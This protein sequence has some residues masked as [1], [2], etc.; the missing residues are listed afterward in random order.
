M[1]NN[2]PNKTSV[3][4]NAVYEEQNLF[5]PP[6]RVRDSSFVKDHA[7]YME[8]YN[9]SINFPTV[10]WAMQSRLLNWKKPFNRVFEGGLL[11]G[12]HNWYIGGKI[13]ASENC[14]DRHVETSRSSKAAIIW[15]GEKANETRT[16][17]YYDLY[18]EVCRFANVLKK[19]GVKKGDM[20]TLYMPQIPETAIAMLACTRIGAVHNVVF[21]GFSAE[22]LRERIIDSGSKVLVTADA[23]NRRGALLP[24]K[25][26]ADEALNGCPAV[27]SCIVVRHTGAAVNFEAPRDKWWHEEMSAQD[28]YTVCLPEEVDSND[29]MFVL[30]TSGSTGKPKGVMHSTAGYLVYAALTTKY[31]F[32]IKDSDTFWCTADAGWITGHTYGL[33]GP[34]LLGATTLMFEGVPTYPKPDRYWEII[35]KYRVSI[36]YTAPTVIRSLMKER[37]EWVNRHNLGSLRILGSVGE[38]INPEVW[39]W[40]YRVVGKEKCAIVDTYWQT[41]TGGIIVTPLP[42]SIPA[43]P[44]SATLPFF[45]IKPTVVDADGRECAPGT[46]G[47]LVITQPWPGLM[48]GIFNEPSR[49]KQSYLTA[50]PGT[51]FTG[52]G[53]VVDGDG[54]LWLLGRVDDVLNV[55]GHRLSTAEIESAIVSHPMVAEAAVVGAPHGIKG[56]SVCAYVILFSSVKPDKDLKSQIKNK[57]REMIGPIASPDDIHFVRDLPKT[58]SGKIIRR[59]L[60]KIAAGDYGQLG[61]LSTLT[62][63]GLVDD[64]IKITFE[65]A[66][67][68]IG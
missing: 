7:H 30:Y 48:N 46:P 26:Y 55:S 44:G 65:S 54:Y 57:V 29:P 2:M 59:V 45:G 62:D 21:G 58:R 37:E 38:P 17:T 52:D 27:K 20:V 60:K 31:V 5:L 49:F 10:F 41:E 43:K 66:N 50:H 36:F 42:G 24:L 9:L 53:A 8:L 16:L 6:Q 3:K 14:L 63:P 19:Q 12:L 35:E 64:I 13:N 22:S 25:E 18:V 68:K 23:G 61:D 56:E 11:D 34:L 39:M 32:D 15:Q 47:H 28:I 33:Y 67:K 40:Y 1:Y 51:Y 4:S